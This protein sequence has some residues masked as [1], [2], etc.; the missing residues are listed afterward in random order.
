ME[1]CN[2]KIQKKVNSLLLPQDCQVGGADSSNIKSGW[3]HAQYTEFMALVSS[4]VFAVNSIFTL[5]ST[6]NAQCSIL[7]GLLNS[8]LP[9]SYC[10][11]AQIQLRD[12]IVMTMGT[13]GAAGSLLIRRYIL[14]SNEEVIEK[15]SKDEI[16]VI[17]DC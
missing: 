14:K 13:V 9:Q 1:N 12:A 3:T 4:I 2:I 15:I 10:L 8:F 7:V 16:K 5:Y 6:Y 17:M 11:Q